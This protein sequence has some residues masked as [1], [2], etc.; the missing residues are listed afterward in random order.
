[1]HDFTGK[2][3]AVAVVAVVAV[4]PLLSGFEGGGGGE[5]HGAEHAAVDVALH[6]QHPLHE[7]GVR[8]KHADAPTGHIVALAHGVELDAALFGSRYAE[9][10]EGMFVQDEA[11]RVVVDDDDA[12]AAGEV[13]QLPV[14]PGGGVG[15]GGHIG[16]VGPHQLHAAQVHLLQ[17][18]EVG[19]PAVLLLQVVVH[20]FRS[21]YLAQR[22]VG[23]I[24]G[25]GNQHLLAGIDEG[26]RDVQDAF[27]GA[28]ER[29]YLRAGVEV[30]VVPL[31]VPAGKTLTQF[32]DADVGHIAVSVGVA[33]GFTK[34]V[35]GLFGG[36][37]IGASDA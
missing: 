17:F 18:V 14:Q 28:D 19:H 5:L 31:L 35:Y 36:R 23:G 2:P 21:Q 33:G 11:V 9:D 34:G 8:G 25:I 26:E 24:T 10:A 1:M 12:F 7:V 30:H 22:G 6:L 16:V 27:F 20:H 32:G 4:V 3:A 29:L 15:S 37:H 13:H